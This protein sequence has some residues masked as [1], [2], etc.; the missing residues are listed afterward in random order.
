MEYPSLK[1]TQRCID[2]DNCIIVCPEESILRT[3]RGLVIEDWSC[4]LCGIC[5]IVC[6]VDAITLQN[7]EVFDTLD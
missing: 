3:P 5:K 4:S 2:C 6:P 7:E 1:I